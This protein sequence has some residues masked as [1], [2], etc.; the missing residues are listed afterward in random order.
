MTELNIVSNFK[1]NFILHKLQIR[2]RVEAALLV[3][4]QGRVGAIAGPAS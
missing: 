1:S 3:Q 2:G 4:R